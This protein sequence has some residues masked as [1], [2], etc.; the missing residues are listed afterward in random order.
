MTLK[1]FPVKGVNRH[2][3]DS[4]L[5]GEPL[6][7]HI[8][9]LGAKSSSHAPHQHEGIEAIYVLEGEATIQ[10]GDETHTLKVN[11]S[12]VF[13]PGKLHQLR[14]DTDSTI[15]YMVIIYRDNS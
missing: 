1:E 14:N 11:E 3:L 4:D 9:E 7:I 6:H 5:N 15:R 10:I 13:E 2:L 12:A 8:S